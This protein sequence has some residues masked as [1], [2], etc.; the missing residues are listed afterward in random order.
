MDHFFSLQNEVKQERTLLIIF[1]CISATFI[2]CHTPRMI[3]N[4]YEFKMDQDKE[5]CLLQGMLLVTK[6]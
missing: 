1:T 5:L 4:I 2:I 6:V 3:L